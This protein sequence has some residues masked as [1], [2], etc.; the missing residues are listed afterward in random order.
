MDQMKHA[1][2]NCSVSNDSD[3]KVVRKVVTR[4]ACLKDEDAC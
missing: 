2:D 4:V 3:Y 1:K